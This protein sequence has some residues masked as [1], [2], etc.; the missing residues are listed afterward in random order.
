MA[1]QAGR[2]SKSTFEENRRTAE[3]PRARSD[4]DRAYGK[5]HEKSKASAE[6]MNVRTDNT[7]TVER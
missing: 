1:S 2:S 4:R 7:M 5:L 6:K 3:P